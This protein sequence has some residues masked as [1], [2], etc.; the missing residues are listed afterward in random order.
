VAI[1]VLGTAWLLS[2]GLKFDRLVMLDILIYGASLIL[3]FLALIL[4]RIR[5]PKLPRPFR[6]P[7]GTL[8]AILIGV[9]PTGLLI[10][11]AVRNRTEHLDLGK[12]GSVSSLSFALGLMALG[13]MVYFVMGRPRTEKVEQAAVAD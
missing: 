3:E 9:M 6:V 7:G 12:L 13:V 4:L 8:G 2:L 1:L 10:F 11:A 5:E